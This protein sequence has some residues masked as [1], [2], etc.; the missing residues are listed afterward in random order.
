MKM[1]AQLKTDDKTLVNPNNYAAIYARISGTKDNNSIHAQIDGAKKVL[2]QRSLLLYGVYEDRVSGHF[3]PPPDR[4]GFGKLLEDAKAGCFKTL[5]AYRHDRLV[6]KLNDWVDL[7]NQLNKLGVKI[8]F[9]DTSEYQSDNS[10]QGDFLENLIVMV[11]ELEP[12]N[13]AERSSKGLDFR[14]KQG[15]YFP[16]GKT[17]F[18]YDREIIGS[19]TSSDS[20]ETKN[21]K[22]KYNKNPL[23]AAFIEYIFRTYKDLIKSGK[24]K[25]SILKDC[26]NSLLTD[27]MSHLTIEGIDNLIT[28]C[29]ESNRTPLLKEI[30]RQL[31]VIGTNELKSKLDSV[32]EHLAG[33]SNNLETIIK[34]EIYFGLILTNPKQKNR[35]IIM[36]KGEPSLDMASFTKSINA[37]KIIPEKNVFETVYCHA[38]LKD[39]LKEEEPDHLFK[40]K[41]LCGKCG[42]KMKLQDHLFN[43]VSS[44]AKINECKSFIKTNL[45]ESILNTIIKD[46][47]SDSSE[48]FNKFSNKIEDKIKV[49]EREILKT[50]SDKMSEMKKYIETKHPSCINN[51]S[52]LNDEL[53][54][55]LKKIAS[56]RKEIDYVNQLKEIVSA[57]NN[58]SKQNKVSEEQLV[59][60][61]LLFTKHIMSNQ[62]IFRPIF[63]RLIKSVRV[64]TIESNE[65]TNCSISI[66]YEYKYRD[67]KCRNI[68]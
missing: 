30:R 46:A 38:N 62:D 26:I 59:L 40:G 20:S 4:K 44:K 63:D 32:K 36:G 57:F 9:S 7:K 16:G 5:V 55:H 29:A 48:G 12:N 18:G 19:N 52:K 21:Y 66:E 10:A 51:I 28:A 27:I 35:G 1:T 6:R 45:I 11:A 68:S 33:T 47:L 49:L 60:I 37:D 50:R 22:S 53:S 39:I 15:V 61:Q 41:I 23:E 8:V 14:R 64:S 2:S 34:N 67:K 65:K 42:V 24:A 13:I 56:F 31:N 43:C 17:P 25:T 3:T 54:S 58:T